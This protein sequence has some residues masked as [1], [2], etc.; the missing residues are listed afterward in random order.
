MEI[1]INI[2]KNDYVQPTE[3]RQEI[4]QKFCDHIIYWM[5]NGA[6][7]NGYEISF[8]DNS[9]RKAEIFLLIR[10]DGT[11]S[12]IASYND[13]LTE[14]CGGQAVKMR[15]VEMKAVFEAMQEAGYFIFGWFC[16]NGTHHYNFNR[17]D[18]FDGRHAEKMEFTVFID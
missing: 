12:G 17:R 8:Y 11:T 5:D 14:K 9:D 15:T 16:T 10:R 6:T 2:P 7:H 1:T 18:Y 13:G 4:V 3:V